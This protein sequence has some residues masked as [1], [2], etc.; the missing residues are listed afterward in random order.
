MNNLRDLLCYTWGITK[1]LVIN[2]GDFNPLGVDCMSESA[3]YKG[4][5]YSCRDKA[6]LEREVKS[7][8]VCEDYFVI[9]VKRRRTGA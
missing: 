6:L 8:G 7:F 2:K 9:E 4:D 5:C 3:L 1:I